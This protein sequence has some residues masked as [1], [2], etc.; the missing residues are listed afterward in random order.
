MNSEI[1]LG[2]SV[3][4]SDP[5]SGGDM[6]YLDM[7]VILKNVLSGYYKVV[8]KRVDTGKYGIRNSIVS[9]IHTGCLDKKKLIWKKYKDDV[10]VDSG[11]AGIFDEKS[12]KNDGSV[13]FLPWIK[14]RAPWKY[15]NN[16]SG[17]MWYMKMSDM[18]LN[19]KEKWGI[20]DN[21]VV[22]SSG[23]GDGNY[24]IYI[25][26]DEKR[27]IIGIAIDFLVR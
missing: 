13:A 12:Y 25:A 6:S 20:Y 5:M 8:V 14:K 19:S 9:V 7:R 2:K 17:G 18:T 26:K 27:R 24:P 22:S 11:Q 21:G 16:K 10:G 4:V 3:V 23:F 1:Y 15:D